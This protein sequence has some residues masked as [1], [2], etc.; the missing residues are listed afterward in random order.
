MKQLHFILGILLMASAFSANAGLANAVYWNF[1]S[2]ASPTSNPFTGLTVA[3]LSRGNGGS[4]VF[5]NNSSPS[6]GYDTAAGFLASGGTNA[7][8]SASAGTLNLSSSTFFAT[9][10]TLDLSSPSALA[11]TGVSSG[12][13]STGTGPASLSLYA[14]AD[15]FSSD[16]E[17]LG[18]IAVSTDSIWAPI[19][20]AGLSLDIN[21]G[22]TVS[23]RLY[24]SDGTSAAAN[25]RIDDLGV[26]LSAAPEPSAVSLCIT[27]GLAGL[28]SMRGKFK[29]R[30]R[31]F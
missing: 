2:T 15:G 28:I 27:S 7:A 26:T 9:A 14:S 23:L 17:A 19:Q 16:F 3:D 13:R 11:I 20:F 5:L 30:R 10:F 21:P 29:K 8:A 25:W 31:A 24:G 22:K 1:L 12:S 18:S 6:S 4:G